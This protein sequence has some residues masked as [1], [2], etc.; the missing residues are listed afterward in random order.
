MAKLP[1]VILLV[2]CII[3]CAA[4]LPFSCGKIKLLLKNKAT[5]ASGDPLTSVT[6]AGSDCLCETIGERKTFLRCTATSADLLP[7]PGFTVN[8]KV[9]DLRNASITHLDPTAFHISPAGENF[10]DIY[11]SNNMLTTFDNFADV[12]SLKFLDLSFNKITSCCGSTKWTNL[13]RV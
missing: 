3:G 7:T 8:N 13:Q 12:A 10:T 5:S 1:K 11:L 6:V 9:L 4:A 2:A